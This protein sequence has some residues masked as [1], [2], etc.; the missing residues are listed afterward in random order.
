MLGT[1]SLPQTRVKESPV[2]SPGLMLALV[3]RQGLG[4]GEVTGPVRWVT[5]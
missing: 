5:S 1:E 4:A 3:P 2:L